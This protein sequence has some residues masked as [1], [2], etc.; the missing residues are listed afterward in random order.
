MNDYEILDDLLRNEYNEISFKLFKTVKIIGIKNT[1]RGDYDKP[2]QFNTRSIASNLI[3]YAN[4]YIELEVELEVPFESGDQGKKEIPSLIALKN[5]YQLVN[6]LD[7]QLDNVVVSNE[8]NIDRANLVNYILNN[9]NNSSTYY[10]NIKKSL[11]LS[12]TNN[13]FIIDSDYYDKK[14]HTEADQKKHFV[15][16]K[17]LIFLKDI[18][19]FF[20]KLD[21]LQYAEFTIDITLDEELFFYKKRCYFI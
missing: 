16:F 3:N 9:G 21:L 17:I 12:L 8:V 5:S 14:D 19:D 11:D 13:K 15:E 1:N 4:A 10:R 20:R 6:N 7:I 18:S 2:I